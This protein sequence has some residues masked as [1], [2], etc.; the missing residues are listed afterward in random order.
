MADHPFI[1][2]RLKMLRSQSSLPFNNLKV[3]KKYLP[4]NC[5]NF[6]GVGGEGVV[7]LFRK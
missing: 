5:P 3:V 2:T 7:R 6:W 1:L 4:K